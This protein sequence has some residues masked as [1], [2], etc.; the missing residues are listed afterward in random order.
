MKRVNYSFRNLFRHTISM[1][2]KILLFCSTA[3]MSPLLAKMKPKSVTFVENSKVIK[4]DDQPL[5]DT[6]IRS[7]SDTVT[8]KASEAPATV[9]PT[10]H[11][12]LG[13]KRINTR[14]LTVR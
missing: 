1:Q 10:G 9:Q 4:T 2:L 8:V 6:M 5:D 12:R 11:R 14:R 7:K 3:E 13:T